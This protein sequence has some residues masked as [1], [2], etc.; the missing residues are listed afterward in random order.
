MPWPRQEVPEGEGDTGFLDM[1]HAYETL[2]EALR[3]Q[4]EGRTIKHDTQ[5]TLDGH[6]RAG[7]PPDDAPHRFL[8]VKRRNS[9]HILLLRRRI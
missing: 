5:Y 2:P 9:Q 3:A 6:D 8:L 1:Y 4:V 7:G